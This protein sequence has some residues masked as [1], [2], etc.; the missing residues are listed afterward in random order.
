MSVAWFRRIGVRG[1]GIMWK[2]N[3]TRRDGHAWVRRPLILR[4][5]AGELRALVPTARFWTWWKL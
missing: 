2:P 3:S 4:T 5:A 1:P